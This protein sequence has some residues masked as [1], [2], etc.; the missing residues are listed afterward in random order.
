MLSED[1]LQATMEEYTVL[2]RIYTDETVEQAECKKTEFD[3]VTFI[4]CR[5]I[6]CNFAGA[7]FCNV[8][9]DNCDFSNCTFTDSYMKNV[10]AQGCKG[11]GS[12]FSNASLKWVKLLE[13]QLRYGNFSLAHLEFCEI[14][15]CCMRESFLSQVKFKKTVCS[16][17]DFTSTDFFRTPLKGMDLSDCNIDNIMVSDQYTELSGMKV[18]L[19]QAA[20]LAKLIGVK[21]V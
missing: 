9:F 13:C 7:S 8:V 15:G 14:S 16:K 21:I 19:F 18:N 1:I 5:F 3:T 10:R 4:R 12:S 2:D 6:A 20:E 17:T 11:D